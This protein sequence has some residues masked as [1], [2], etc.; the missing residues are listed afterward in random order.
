[1]F[2]HTHT[3]TLRHGSVHGKVVRS[4]AEVLVKLQEASLRR[5]TKLRK[6]LSQFSIFQ[7]CICPT[8]KLLP[9]VQTLAVR[10]EEAWQA[11]DV[12]R[13]HGSILCISESLQQLF[14]ESCQAAFLHG[15]AEQV[16]DG[17]GM[18][19]LA[20]LRMGRLE[21]PSTLCSLLFSIKPK[22]TRRRCSLVE[23]C[24]M[25]PSYSTH[26]SNWCLHL[27]PTMGMYI[28]SLSRPLKWWQKTQKAQWVYSTLRTKMSHDL[29]ESKG[30]EGRLHAVS[31]RESFPPLTAG[32]NWQGS[33]F[34]WQLLTNIFPLHDLIVS[35]DQSSIVG[36]FFLPCSGSELPWPGLRIFSKFA[37]LGFSNFWDTMKNDTLRAWMNSMHHLAPVSIEQFEKHPAAWSRRCRIERTYFLILWWSSV[38]SLLKVLN[39]IVFS[40]SPPIP[41]SNS[42]DLS[43]RQDVSASWWGNVMQIL[44]FWRL[45][46]WTIWKRTLFL[47]KA[48]G[49]LQKWHECRLESIVG[50]LP[51]QSMGNRVAASTAL[52]SVVDALVLQ[53]LGKRQ[54]YRNVWGF[55]S[56]GRSIAWFVSHKNSNLE[57]Q[58]SSH[59]L[60]DSNSLHRR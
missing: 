58:R 2:S 17:D 5:E 52:R 29:F 33:H 47:W 24:G 51:L 36:S 55:T 49:K 60:D 15:F 35:A 48:V 34:T 19:T 28:D 26:Q 23:W 31:L 25:L 18:M 3:H 46:G 11:G 57:P 54:I 8:T 56:H 43:V 59:L 22:E 40:F 32:W 1:M 21:T 14:F 27:Y 20:D 53:V 12:S 30:S 6:F 39:A 45:E 38:S 10:S 4:R 37:T 16:T 9:G 44:G 41:E 42:G 50:L 13:R 7:C